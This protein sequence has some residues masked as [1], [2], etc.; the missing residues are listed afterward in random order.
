MFIEALQPAI[1]WQGFS[2]HAK[3]PESVEYPIVY[4]CPVLDL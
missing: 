4:I 1:S 2:L 3:C